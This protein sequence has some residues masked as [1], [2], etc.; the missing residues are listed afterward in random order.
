MN[1]AIKEYYSE[2]ENLKFYSKNEQSTKGAFAN[3]LSLY[4]KKQDLILVP[5]LKFDNKNIPDGTIKDNFRFSFGY[6]EAKDSKDNLDIEIQKKISKGYPTD[7]IIFEDTTRAVLY[8]NQE[9]VLDIDMQDD[10]KLENLLNKFFKFEKA[11][12]YEFHTAIK[13]FA[14]DIPTIIKPIK[15]EIFKAQQSNLK[16]KKQLDYFLYICQESINPDINEN[17]IYEMLIQHIL[18]EDIFKR[19]FDDDFHSNNTIARELNKLERTFLPRDTKKNLFLKISY[20]YEAIKSHSLAISDYK[21]KQKFL[22]ILYE[23]FYKAYNPKS[24]D[25]LGI[26][27]TPLEIVD[28]MINMVDDLSH[29]HFNKS[30]PDDGVK[31]LDPCIGTGTFLSQIIDFIPEHKLENKFKNELFANE[32]SILPY[33]IANINL[34][35]IYFKKKNKYSEFKNIS[36]ADT[37]ELNHKTDKQKDFFN[38]TDENSDRIKNQENT[39]ID[40]IIG[41]PPYNANQQNENDNNKNREYPF[42]DSRI[43]ATYVKKSS[44]QKTKVY[45]MYARFYRWAT[46]RIDK[47]GMVAFITNSSF[48]DSKTFDG[49]RADVYSEFNEIYIIDL[50][51]NIRAGDKTGNIF[52]IMVGVA[53][54]VLIKNAR[55]QNCKL[56]YFKVPA[57]GAAQKLKFLQDY[58]FEDLYHRFN[59]IIPDNR[60]NWLNQ[61]DND[62]DDLLP[63]GTKKSKLSKSGVE[64]NSIFKLYSLGVSTNRD[65][66]VYDFSK[67]N[68][69]NK[70]KFFIKQYNKL[71]DFDTIIKWSEALKKHHVLNKKLSFDNKK[72][73]KSLYRPFIKKNLYFD[74]ILNDRQGQQPL[75]F[76]KP[77]SKNLV[78]SVKQGQEYPFFVL[79]SNV[80]TEMQFQ[81]GVQQFSLYTYQN[82]TKTENIT[83]FGSRAFQKH[84]NNKKITKQDIFYYCYGVLHY[85]T[86]RQKYKIN[87]KQDLPRIPF[88][89]DFDKFKNIGEN[90]IN[91]HLNYEKIVPYNLL[92]I[93]KINDKKINKVKLKISPCRGKIL[94]DEWTTLENFP[95]EALDY[96][97]GNRSAVEWVLDGY[98]EKK[99]KDPTVAQNFNNYKFTDYKDEVIGLL[100]KITNLSLQ[101]LTIIKKY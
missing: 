99:I 26:V 101:H 16:F 83:Q 32:I 100:K 33:Y 75:F 13:Q 64:I 65:N 47:N 94:I 15:K 6:W 45:D 50:G 4:A 41:N 35:Y 37:L 95:R 66:W 91:L 67:K 71:D 98:K 54:M 38:L 28:F 23:N 48:I 82:N 36:F 60:H 87:L 57:I 93:T 85:P 44:A 17:D 27:Y 68:L 7:N 55:K 3:L 88:Y 49:F 14:V 86:Y 18:T 20:Y 73:V 22:N 9:M 70:V 10:K 51:G 24:A 8:Q 21:E 84:Y 25:K 40:I 92:E 61:T 69:K 12:I 79:S 31:I 96:K 80:L 58:K 11:E 74:N 34:E 90:L 81:G 63:M 2:L 42:I 30:I 56:N 72:I 59:S 52:N 5:E 53:I 77:D 19:L 46:D 97:L 39:Q 29:Q 1:T 76:P 89:D 43:K 62:W 78:I